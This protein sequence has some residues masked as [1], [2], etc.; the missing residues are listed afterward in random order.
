VGFAEAAVTMD[1]VTT[2]WHA[3]CHRAAVQ[4]GESV[5]VVGAGGLGLNAV[6]VARARGARVAAVD[7]AQSRRDEARRLGAEAAVG[8]GEGP[9]LRQWAPD[10]VDV[11]IEASGTRNGLDLALR[12]VRR[13]G[14][15]A[16][17]GY[18]PGLELTIESSRLAMEE[19]TI[20]GCRAGRFDDAAAALA[21]VE[22]GTIRPMVGGNL[23]L[24]RVNEG[25]A[26]LRDGSVVGR[27]VVSL[28]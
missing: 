27:V 25:L 4:P 22:A 3:L 7:P 8:P 10:G 28:L 19:L 17:C 21:A 14:R 24:E 26:S 18:R 9:A 16:C 12:H 2:P 20:L 23:P 6:Q 1:A 5:L 13:G 11:V 15:L